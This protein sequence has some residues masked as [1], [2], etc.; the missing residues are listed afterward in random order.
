MTDT[1]TKD[2][3]WIDE[4]EAMLDREALSR[5]GVWAVVVFTALVWGLAGY[6]WVTR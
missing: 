2:G 1:E 5:G 4:A 6:W 3:A